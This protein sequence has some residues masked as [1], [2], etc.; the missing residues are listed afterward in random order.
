MNFKNYLS[1]FDI[2]IISK[3]L[4]NI[5][6]YINLSK[7]CKSYNVIDKY[8]YNPL[9]ISIEQL[10]IFDNLNNLIIENSDN[11][12]VNII[13]FMAY[14]KSILKH[15]NNKLNVIN[16]SEFNIL[17]YK[18]YFNE[19]QTKLTFRD[20]IDNGCNSDES[21]YITKIETNTFNNENM[22]YIILPKNV[23]E[24]CE[25]SIVNCPEL[26][27]II[28]LRNKSDLSIHS[29]NF[30]GCKKYKGIIYINNFN[31][32]ANNSYSKNITEK[33]SKYGCESLISY[34]LNSINKGVLKE[35]IYYD[36]F[37]LIEDNNENKIYKAYST[38]KN[39]Y[40]KPKSKIN[41]IN[42]K[43]FILNNYNY[44]EQFYN[45]AFINQS[46]NTL[47]N[48]P[49]I[50]E[51]IFKN[52][53]NENINIKNNINNVNF[54]EN[55]ENDIIIENKGNKYNNENK[56]FYARYSINDLLDDI[57]NFGEMFKI[58]EM[59]KL[60]L[61][62]WCIESST[63]IN[64]FKLQLDERI[65]LGINT[66]KFIDEIIKRRF[67]NQTHYN[68]NI[69]S[70]L[71]SENNIELINDYIEDL[72]EDEDFKETDKFINNLLNQN[73]N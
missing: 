24:I 42:E 27:F 46:L 33:F 25:K 13:E 11:D 30:I 72:N 63:N 60:N 66:N 51:F 54:N 58:F 12:Y 9:P 59:N 73:M 65:N 70:E 37:K 38:S 31:V 14:N 1:Q 22:K 17:K 67:T 69:L 35:G 28:C 20:W 64:D 3:Y 52:K 19:I 55:E 26:L 36:D 53:I 23:N 7:T 62:K 57:N 21:K 47:I 5:Y 8:N 41:N 71:K 50:N 18:D 34:I 6:D 15:L 16:K 10:L 68:V 2:I 49:K 44:L 43:Y 56:I 61:N 4:N 32:N 29:N 48:Y 40:F 45:Y 39:I